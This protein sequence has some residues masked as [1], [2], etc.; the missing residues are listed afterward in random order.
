MHFTQH[1]YSGLPDPDLDAQFY[2]SV[3]TRRLIAWGIDGVITFGITLA[4]SIFT[5]G[6]GFFIFPMMWLVIGFFYRS[7]SISAK[8][9]TPGMRLVGIEFRDRQGQRLSTALALAHTA[10]F[11]F[12]SGAMVL[13]L[14]SIVMIL[15]TRY[16]QSL[17]DLILGTTAINRPA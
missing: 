6:V 11:T 12:A 7:A 13:Q 5:F 10:I 16:G 9:A 3:P 4:L 1:A 8:S 2:D 17:Q 15:S 14:L